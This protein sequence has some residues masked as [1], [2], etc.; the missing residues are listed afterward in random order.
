MKPAPSES[1]VD[2][3]PRTETVPSSGSRMRESTRQSV[4][5]PAPFGPTTPTTWPSRQVRSTSRSAQII[6]ALRRTP[7]P[8][9]ALRID[10]RERLWSRK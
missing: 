6:G 4:L 5:L 3:W 8:S 7:P 10:M 9:S 1:S 2:T